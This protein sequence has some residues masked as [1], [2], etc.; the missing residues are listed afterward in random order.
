M[1]GNVGHLSSSSLMPFFVGIRDRT[2]VV[3]F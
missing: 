1:S 3:F 2:T